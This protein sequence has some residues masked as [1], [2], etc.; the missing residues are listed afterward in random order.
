MHNRIAQP[1]RAALAVAALAGALAAAPAGA[2]T[3]WN[4]QAVNPNG[5]S[6][7]APSYPLT[8][9]GVLLTDPDEMLDATPNFQL[10]SAGTMGGEWQMVVQAVWPGDRGGTVCWMGQNYALRRSPGDDS[11]S[12]SN[13]AWLAE[14][15]RLNHD[16][17][18]GHAFRKGDLLHVQ[19]Q[20][21]QWLEGTELKAE[22]S[23]QKVMLLDGS[24]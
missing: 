9:V 10:A 17:A 5:T 2:E 13:E 21:R 3:H 4:L 16:P 6:A 11:F 7:W 1:C 19:L 24:P 18:T 20:T 8:V 23:I 22:H 12:Y 15:A 14:M